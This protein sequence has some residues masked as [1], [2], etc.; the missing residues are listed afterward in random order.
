MR[1]FQL[2]SGLL[3]YVDRRVLSE[4]IQ[5]QGN[6]HQAEPNLS[7]VPARFCPLNGSEQ[8]LRLT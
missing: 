6:Y 5:V 8:S 4:L 7:L 2:R 1:C 3:E